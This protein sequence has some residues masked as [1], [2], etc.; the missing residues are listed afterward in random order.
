M[1][2]RHRLSFRPR[3]AGIIATVVAAVAASVTLGSTAFAGGTARPALPAHAFTPYFQAYTDASPARQSRASGAKYLTMAFLQ[4]AET[5]SCN[6]LWNG[7]KTKPVAHSIFGADIAKIRARGGDVI[8]SFG[9]FSADDTATEIADSCTSVSSIAQQMENVI[10]TYDV[11]RLD[12]DVEDNSL[13]NPAGSTAGTRR[14]TRSS[15]GRATTA[16]PSSSSTPSRPA[17]AAW[18]RPAS[19]CWPT[20]SPTT[21][22]S[23]S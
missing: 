15:S 20:R 8:P 19:T 2:R 22:A 21:R 6:I 3:T 14:S 12:M 11:T 23:T 17:R 4:T 9:G 5:G 18:S 1:T 16:G 7:D 13:T 10:T